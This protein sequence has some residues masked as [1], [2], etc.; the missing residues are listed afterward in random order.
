VLTER[1]L[2]SKA[3]FKY[4]ALRRGE[5]GSITQIYKLLADL[6]VLKS[7][8]GRVSGGRGGGLQTRHQG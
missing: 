1:Q 2:W 5:D 7:L 4:R 6:W 3:L 8:K